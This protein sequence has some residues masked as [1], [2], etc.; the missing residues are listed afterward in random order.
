MTSKKTYVIGC[1]VLAVDIRHIAEKFGM[2]IGTKF[3][4]A[5]LHERP[6]MLRE[7][8][9]AAIDEVSASGLCHRIVI[10]YGICGRGTVGI[11]AR[12]V[13]L[14]IPKVHDCISLFLGGDDAYQQQFKKYP[15][16][17]YISAGWFEEK[18]TPISQRKLWANFGEERLG[19]DEVKQQFGEDAANE[20]FRFL[21]S[22]QKNYQRA[23]FIETGS[24]QSPKYEQS[25]RE[26]AEE[27][28]WIYEKVM[29]DRTLIHKMLTAEE[30]SDDIL[31]V[32]PDQVIEFDPI[33][34]TLTAHPL[35]AERIGDADAPKVIH[36][37]GEEKGEFTPM[38]IGVGIDAGGTYTDTVIYDMEQG[39]T[40][41][42][43]KALTTKWDFTVGIS[44]ALSGLDQDKLCRAE[45]VALSTTLATNA[46]VEGD[47]QKVGTILMPPYGMFEPED[48]PYE[49]R[50]LVA[51]RLDISGR[52]LAPVDDGEV[53]RVVRE[54]V[55][56]DGVRA[57]AVSGFA[58]AVNPSHE[59]MVKRIIREETGFFVTC[60]HELSDLLNFKIRA[61]TAMLNAR[62]IPR[63][64][65]LL[66]DLETV[67]EGMGIKAPVV[68]VKGD[69]TLMSGE[70]AKAR[71]VETILS[72][73]AASVAGA[74]HLTGLKDALVVDMG[75]TT[76]DTAALVDGEVSV[77]DAGSDVG[78]RKT[79]VKA[80]EIR[81]AGLGGDSLISLEKD[82]FSIGPRRV[83]PIAW[84]GANYP[85]TATALQYLEKH[86]NRF[87][88]SAS[89]MQILALT[90][91][92]DDF[93][94]SP[95]EEE[96]LSLLKS[97]PYSV[98]E[99]IL[100]TDVFFEGALNLERLEENYIIQR[101]GL[102]P[103]DL[104]HVTGRFEPWDTRSARH[105]CRIFSQLTHREIPG[106]ADHLL[107]MVVEGL[108]LEL[109]KRQLDNETDPEALHTCPVCRTLMKNLLAGGNSEYGVHIDLKRPVVGIG[110]PIAYFLPKAA[111]ALGAE[112]ILPEDADVANAI[113]AIT[114]RVVVKRQVRIVPGVG[115][116]F[117][118][119]GLSNAGIFN[120]FEDA[121]S[122]AVDELVRLVRKQ[123]RASGTSAG[124]VVLEIEDQM[125][126]AAGGKPI[127][128]GRIIR[129]G[130][131][132]RP[133]IV[134]GAGREKATVA[135]F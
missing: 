107:D 116:G 131:T 124:D 6:D 28:G 135:G 20:T 119:E 14:V 4:E 91:S 88:A 9:Q 75:G 15:G 129:A 113:G 87:T 90:S 123:G 34:S 24:K 5:G 54:M 16:T 92:G 77:C 52:E 104:L 106:M 85:G 115:R 26:M 76:T 64:A 100:E 125:P 122:F 109:L 93:E 132:G 46:I 111:K 69:G 127:F 101:C 1:A 40:L 33:Q 70:M 39:R 105:F 44:R 11:Q 36:L 55:E 21:N 99:L 108:A 89:G 48:F 49:P 37:K 25:A 47:G 63:L 2:D 45:M 117:T 130:L 79:H 72:G 50:A 35:W 62:I 17:Y 10:G 27:Y 82:V 38:K 32:P 7:Q 94:L 110:A 43:S 18:T 19:F 97:R 103:T 8:L 118:I 78:G 102:T 42:K 80:L 59:L 81:T 3:L 120:E 22:W 126:V 58:G 86:L 71:P 57:F 30:T 29:G 13:P 51:G 12:N 121:Y 65:K 95:L 23:A 114:S 134:L 73:P 67:M 41:G 60:G 98:D 31:V 133:D 68:V 84:L 112:A 83:A 96:I 66:L 74:R 53:R 56:K 61:H 128:V